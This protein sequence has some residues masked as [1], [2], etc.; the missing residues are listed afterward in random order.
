MEDVNKFLCR[1]CHYA[2][3]VCQEAKSEAEFPKSMWHNRFSKDQR[4]LCSD[5]SRPRC[6]SQQC[7]TCG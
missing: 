1:N 6:T 5:C 4:S 3:A 7:K 2:C